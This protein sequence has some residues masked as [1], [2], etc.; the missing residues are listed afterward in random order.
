MPH[1][2]DLSSENEIK[3]KKRRISNYTTTY[4]SRDVEEGIGAHE[5]EAFGAK[6]A[7]F[8]M[9]GLEAFLNDL[10][11]IFTYT[12]VIIFY[13]EIGVYAILIERIGPLG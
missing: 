5:Q 3:Y 12:F 13:I 6:L 2:F 8:E 11:S 4:V 9:N 7:R 1:K 10:V